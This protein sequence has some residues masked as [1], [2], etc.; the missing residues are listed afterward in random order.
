MSHIKLAPSLLAAN[1]LNLQQD[2]TAAQ[3]AGCE[4]LHFDVMDGVFVGN[5]SFGLPLLESIK[6]AVTHMVMDCHLMIV[7]PSQYIEVFANAGADIIT[8]H[9]EI[10]EDIQ[11]NID[12][13]KRLGKKVGLAINPKTDT[14]LVL[15]YLSHIDMLTVMT[16]QAGFGGQKFMPEVV[17]NIQLFSDYIKT[18]NLSVDIQIDGGVNLTTVD[19]VLTAG[20]NVIVAGSAIFGAPDIAQAVTDFRAKF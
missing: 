15:P 16:V 17:P 10:A 19:S 2:I 3:Q 4:Y 14:S 8:F 9:I 5:I 13:I 7:K 6:P 20:A 1:F 12:H 11:T 18:H